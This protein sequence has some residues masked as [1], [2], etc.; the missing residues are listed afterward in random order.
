MLGLAFGYVLRAALVPSTVRRT[1]WITALA[2]VPL[3]AIYVFD[4]LPVAVDRSMREAIGADQT[5]SLAINVVIWWTL[6]TIVSVAISRII[7]NLRR[8]IRQ[9]MQL[10]QYTLEQ[11]LGEGGMGVVYRASHAMMR[12]PTA[13]K[14]LSREKAGEAS[15]GEVRARG[16][17]D[18]EVD[19]PEHHHHL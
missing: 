5:V 8:E 18:G 16:A 13:V 12:R 7:H 17:A 15:L 2:V 4:W 10:G 6:V 9:A 1:V 3:F 19:P 14:L 11:E